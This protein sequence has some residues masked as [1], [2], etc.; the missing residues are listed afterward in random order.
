MSSHGQ[1]ESPLSGHNAA[2]LE[3]LYNDFA[4]NPDS[5][6]P[7]W[8]VWFENIEKNV[9]ARV[10]STPKKTA[11][12]KPVNGAGR[13]QATRAPVKPVAPVNGNH[14]PTFPP[15]PPP[16]TESSPLLQ[17]PFEPSWSSSHFA[18]PAVKSESETL[19]DE[20]AN[21]KSVDL[22]TEESRIAFLKSLRIFSTLSD[23][24][25]KEVLS[26]AREVQF[27]DGTYV[28]RQ[29][30]L[31]EDLYII[32]SGS[33]QILRNG[34][35]LLDLKAREV[36][37]ELAVLDRKP[38]SAD[39]IADDS[40]VV[41]QIL[42]EELHQLF[43]KKQSLPISF[44]KM[45]AER[46]RHSNTRQERVDQLIR[47]F[48]VRG[49]VLA[50]VDP[51]GLRKEAHPELTLEHYNFTNA[52]LD[53]RFAVRIGTEQ[54]FKPLRHIIRS[55]HQTY[56]Q[57]IGA[58]YMHIDDLQIQQWIQ[59]QLEDDD[60]KTRLSR[61][62]Q[63]R[64]LSKLTDAEVFET[65]LGKKYLGAKRF[66]L[67]GAESLIPLL[68][69][70][71]EI[72][73]DYGV[74]QVII[75]MAHRGRLNVLANTLNK[76]YS[77]IFREFED[78]DPDLHE[79]AGD[80]KYHLGYSHDLVTSSGNNVHLSLCFNPSHLAFVSPVVLGRSRAKLD[81]SKKGYYNVL[82]II[83]HGDAAFAGQGVIQ[84]VFNLS[85]LP[86]YTI[87]GA[88]HI[89]VN[90]QIGFT[91]S[92]EE[93]RSSRYATDVA[94]MLQIPIF[95]V[96]GEDPEAVDR[97]IK[98]AM[99]FREAFHKD[100]VIDM[101]SYRRHGHNEGDE[102]RFTQPLL[103]EAI[104]QRKSVREAYIENLLRLGE[105]TQEE[106]E[107]IAVQSRNHLESEL[108][109]ARKPDYQ[110]NPGEAGQGVW[111]SYQ[112]GADTSV[113]RVDTSVPKEH[114]SAILQKLSEF[115]EDFNPHRKIVRFLK[116][117]SDMASGKKPLNWG[118]A[119]ALAF[120]TLLM[121]GTPIRFTG[122]DV[123]RGTFS[124]RHM[125]MH[126]SHSDFRYTP[127]RHLSE[128]Q[129]DLRTHN[130][131]LSEIAVLGYEF[132][133]SLDYPDALVVWEAQFGD[134]CNVAQVIID[135]FISSSEVKWKRLS[136]LVMLLP[137]GFE[138]Q[139]PEHS[140]ARL[141][142]FL[143]LAAEDNMQVVN[144]TTPAQYFHCL[145]RQVLRPW[146][147]PLIV[148]S[149]KSLLRHKQA[150]STLDELAEGQFQ[151]VIADIKP[152]AKESVQRILIC[153]GKVYYEL[154][155]Y[156]TKH[157]IENIALLRL[158]Q[159]YPLPLEE[160][161]NVLAEYPEST[162]VVWVQEEPENMGA[163]PFLRLRVGHQIKGNGQHPL[164]SVTRAECAS[165]AT[166]SK[167]SHNLE[168]TEL[169]ETAMKL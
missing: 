163:W 18:L 143:T 52:D 17:Q 167:A 98:V 128:D 142:R 156:R 140:S 111:S 165:P 135:Q 159:Y 96:N 152:L 133:Y 130:S 46:I 148:M 29:G 86:G 75:G 97:V 34:R 145:R 41:L 33:V 65:F 151:R 55:L 141:E 20:V 62:E 8:R 78:M 113:S 68:D 129:A 22:S 43:E 139:G 169:I 147:K 56:C 149:P 57:S 90:N 107:Q 54:V 137:H 84:E 157:Q 50:K 30:E 63:L 59:A 108:Q 16:S 120:G 166:G 95:H 104:S 132:G 94:R 26:I 1:P 69:E 60:N 106:A 83:I 23:D 116:T 92:P 3:D 164:R 103:Y 40:L 109:E 38:R 112:G 88:V 123:E 4:Q 71:L 37:G 101:Y 35:H 51:L 9:P 144:L 82:P 99:R 161:E 125:I 67:E 118:A 89:I 93:A 114:L 79:G 160:L 154:E 91:T 81:R 73:G 21:T 127:L 122:Q 64:I 102:P 12:S 49:H 10:S 7:E 2:F 44:M 150:S 136:G 45:L 76:P 158:E 134:F 105:V 155:D 24:E 61:G 115:P 74:D 15:Y 58:Q 31:G 87:G 77:Q 47:A 48:R 25:I 19:P 42:G 27:P 131:P 117:R 6:S 110:Y 28:C 100:I 70:A 11:K 162:E 168:Q 66:S 72:A 13:K 124:H 32:I 153:S 126:D 14:E 5:V 36:V 138:G 119:E 39:V 121:Q 146:R 80:V 85:E 53:A